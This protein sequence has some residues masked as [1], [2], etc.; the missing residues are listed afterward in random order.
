MPVV[1]VV[2]ADV[3]ERRLVAAVS[4]RLV[5]S[6]Y[7]LLEGLVDGVANGALGVQGGQFV[8]LVDVVL[9]KILDAVIVKHVEELSECDGALALGGEQEGQ[10]AELAAEAAQ[11]LWRRSSKAV[12]SVCAFLYQGVQGYGL[13]VILDSR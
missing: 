12:H 4:C 5:D 3:G 13:A 11:V 9:S 7:D 2:V 10:V 8:N 6:V 1:A